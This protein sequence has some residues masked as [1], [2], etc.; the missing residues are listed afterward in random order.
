MTATPPSPAAPAPYAELRGKAIGL[1]A[2]LCAAF[3]FD[4]LDTSMVNVAIPDVGR[5]L[6][7]GS[8]LQWV[9]SGYILGYGGFL[10]FGGRMADLLGRRQVFLIALAAF[11]VFSVL[12]GLAWNGDVLIASRFLKGIAAAFTAPAALSL[13]TTS[14]AEGAARNRAL[15]LYTATGSAGFTFGLIFGGLLTGWAWR[16]VFFMPA[17]V[18]LATLLVGVATIPR[19][20]RDPESRARH[21]IPG[22]VT[23]TGAMMAIVYALTSG[24]A[25]G[26]GAGRTVGGFALG[27]VL[28]VAFVLVERVH[29]HPLVPLGLFRSWALI[30]GNLAALSFVGG[31]AAAQYLITLYLQN[32]R[33]WGPLQTAA[34]FWPCGILGLFVA[35]YIARLIDRVGLLTV[36]ALGLTMAAVAYALLLLLDRHTN[37][38]LGLFPTFALIGIAFTLVFSTVSIAATTGVPAEE[39]GLASGLLQSAIQFGSAVL[40]AVTTAVFTSRGGFSTSSSTASAV[41]GSYHAGWSVPLVAA[42]VSLILVALGIPGARRAARRA[43]AQAASARVTA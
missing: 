37:Y 26:W 1:L 42:L 27:A 13:V 43:S 39:Q 14:F 12:G 3:F 15:S 35:P 19:Q 23:I 31:W 4:A 30:R 41:M 22:A 11:V 36:L 8:Q 21:D 28:L 5:A 29:T 16:A 20:P 6:S 38:W 17:A 40:L 18:G 9:V 34:A 25:D 10:L 32:T 7:L 33:G 24:P 2:V